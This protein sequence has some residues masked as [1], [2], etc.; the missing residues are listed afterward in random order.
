MGFQ[1]DLDALIRPLDPDRHAQAI[2][3]LRRCRSVR[4]MERLA[5]DGWLM[6]A[7]ERKRLKLVRHGS[8]AFLVVEYEDGWSTRKALQEF[9]GRRF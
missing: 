2:A 1:A 6:P 7:S 5:A 3:A 9:P 8:G 4:D